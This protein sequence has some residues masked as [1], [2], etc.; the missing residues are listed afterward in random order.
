MG[1]MHAS[2]Q[3]SE[4]DIRAQLERLI[5]S[6]GLKSSRALKNF[7]RYIVLEKLDGREQELKEYNIAVKG[8]H[9][10]ESFNPQH[11]ALI[12]IYALRLR[13]ILRQYYEQEGM[14][15]L[16][17]IIIPKGS[18]KPVFQLNH[19]HAEALAEEGITTRGDAIAMAVF[20]FHNIDKTSLYEI[21]IDKLCEQISEQ[22]SD[23]KDIKIISY[24]LVRSYAVHVEDVQRTGADLGANVLVTGSVRFQQNY[25]YV[26]LQLVAASTGIQLWAKDFE[27]K[28]RKQS[29]ETIA[30]EVADAI[31]QAIFAQPAGKEM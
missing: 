16:I 4:S 29:I 5:N 12:R 9:R 26:Q 22:L 1:N 28:L 14:N 20:P 30:R 25:L 2:S 24:L 17:R 8:L 23:K 13:R 10:P 27:Y 15:D 3:F 19:I 6:P 21:L 11:F 7:L 31:Y 18:Y